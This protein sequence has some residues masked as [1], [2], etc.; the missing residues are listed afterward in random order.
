M[1]I[2][3]LLSLL[4]TLLT[5][6][7]N[8][9]IDKAFFELNL[10]ANVDV[11]ST[12]N[13]SYKSIKVELENFGNEDIKVHFPPG[14]IF[15]NLD[16]TEQNL[17]VLFY[18]VILLKAGETESLSLGTS[19]ANPKRKIPSNGRTTWIYDYDSKIGELIMFYHENKAIVEIA[20]GPEHHDTFEKRHNFLQM[21]VWVYY[22]AEKE[23][24][25]SFATTYLF[26][27]DK[28][29]AKVFVDAFYPLAVTFID[30]YKR[31]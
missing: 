30:L 14:G 24:I 13:G 19:C 4:I 23:Q 25:L 2:K 15:I 29:E 7:I 26:D 17:V 16:S 1:K 28:E 11:R 6:N 3:I 27:G 22:N 9:Q 20:T 31:I 10:D 18:D 8:A 21:C 12:S 5:T